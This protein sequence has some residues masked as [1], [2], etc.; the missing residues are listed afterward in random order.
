MR[1]RLIISTADWPEAIV[2][3]VLLPLWLLA[4]PHAPM[5]V[6]VPIGILVTL[7]VFYC[8]ASALRERWHL[9]KSTG[10]FFGYYFRLAAMAIAIVI[11]WVLLVVVIGRLFFT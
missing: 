9:S 2:F 6:R 4:L 1:L 3:A 5:F 10:Q 11:A 8:A 7:G